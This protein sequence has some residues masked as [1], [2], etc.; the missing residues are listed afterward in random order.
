MLLFILTLIQMRGETE[1][2]P[3][4]ALNRISSAIKA[5]PTQLDWG[6]TNGVSSGA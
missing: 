5:I 3:E 4:L 6:S 2:Q 1:K